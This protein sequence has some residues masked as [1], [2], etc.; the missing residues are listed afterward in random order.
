MIKSFLVLMAAVFVSALHAQQPEVGYDIEEYR[1]AT[2]D[3]PPRYIPIRGVMC[4]VIWECDGLLTCRTGDSGA[5]AEEGKPYFSPLLWALFDW[6]YFSETGNPDKPHEARPHIQGNTKEKA[7]DLVKRLIEENQHDCVNDLLDGRITPLSLAQDDDELVLLL[8]K[9]GADP[10][11]G[12]MALAQGGGSDDFIYITPLNKAAREGRVDTVKNLLEHGANPTM[13]AN[14]GLNRL[15]ADKGDDP[16]RA[17]CKE[18]ILQA[19]KGR[20]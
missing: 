15:F 4:Q 2:R 18:L 14:P 1:G 20:E 17:K 13:E 12:N 16:N 5:E 3:V 7:R 6:K 11:K 19:Q 9:K 10:N 8:L